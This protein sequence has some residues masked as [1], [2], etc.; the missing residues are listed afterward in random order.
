MTLK[1]F[2][3]ATLQKYESDV[4]Y[5]LI[6][7]THYFRI[8]FQSVLKLDFCFKENEFYFRIIMISLKNSRA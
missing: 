3:N 6:D 1:H 4:C 7:N 2:K 8:T 5:W